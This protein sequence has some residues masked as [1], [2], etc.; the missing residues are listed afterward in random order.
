MTPIGRSGL[1]WACALFLALAA[2]ARGQHRLVAPHGGVLIPFGNEFAHLE[3]LLEPD[4]GRLSAWVLDGEAARGVQVAQPSLV[5]VASAAD[6]PPERIVLDAVTRTLTGERVGHTSEFGGTAPWLRGRR[7]FDGMLERLD[8]GGARLESIAFNYP[9]GREAHQDMLIGLS[10]ADGGR[11]I[12]KHPLGGEDVVATLSAALG[13]TAVYGATNPGFNGVRL[14]DPA[15]GVFL[16]PDGMELRLRITSIDPEVA[17]VM[18]GGRLDA[19]G[20]EAVIGVA[21][22]LHVHPAWQVVVPEGRAGTFHVAFVLM[23]SASGVGP[24]EEARMRLR[25]ER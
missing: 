22:D 9:R 13:G 18:R 17:V 14:P 25:V 19:V 15:H 3:L 21:P 6:G 11:V 12:L 8:L 24:S 7:E 1:A 10:E 20:E 4:A 16:V 23:A 5:I 2:S